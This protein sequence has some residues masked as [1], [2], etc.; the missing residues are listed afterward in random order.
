M[1]NKHGASYGGLNM[2]D[3][4]GKNAIRYE[5]F[6]PTGMRYFCSEKCWAEYNAMPVK[7]EG[8][9]GLEKLE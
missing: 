8:Y 5:A 6:G 4:C 9:Y 1:R 2:C 3:M 7:E